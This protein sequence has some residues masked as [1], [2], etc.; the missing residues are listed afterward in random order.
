MR[1]RTILLDIDGTIVDSNDAHAR[2]WVDALASRGFGVSFGQVRP[3][4]GMGGDKLLRAV[5]GLDSESAEGKAISSERQEL[6]RTKYLP[7]LQPT[8]GA[9]QL[10]EWLKQHDVTVGIATSAK[11][12]EVNGL[13]RAATVADLIDYT[14]SS[15]DAEESKPDPDIVV[16]ALRR[17]GTPAATAIMIGDTPY[18]IEAARGASV[19]TIALRSG[20]WKDA[21]LQGAVAIFD[22]PADLLQN[23][24]ASPLAASGGG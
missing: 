12:D 18:D 23:V 13:L 7:A 15:D 21:D 4:I 16:A 24:D 3:L 1:Y 8:P 19:D 11:A 9:R 17:I 22:N 20:G 10:I 14:T 5:A 2:A 6:F